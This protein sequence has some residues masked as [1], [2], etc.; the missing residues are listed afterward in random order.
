MVKGQLPALVGRML[1]SFDK[2]RLEAEHGSRKLTQVP[3]SGSN[4]F[5]LVDLQ[6][7]GRQSLQYPSFSWLVE[8]FQLFSALSF[9]RRHPPVI[10]KVF[11]DEFDPM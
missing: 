5:R 9:F 3:L 11:G 4:P 8:H 2:F 1:H 10:I 6:E 7:L